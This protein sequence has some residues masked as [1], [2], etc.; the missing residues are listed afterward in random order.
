VKWLK[1]LWPVG[2]AC[3]LLGLSW[4]LSYAPTAYVNWFRLFNG[5]VILATLV[6]VVQRVLGY[7]TALSNHQKDILE[8]IS[9]GERNR[10]EAIDA[11]MQQ[12]ADIAAELAAKTVNK[13]EALMQQT[14]AQHDELSTHIAA[15]SQAFDSVANGTDGAV[16]DRNKIVKTT[17]KG[18]NDRKS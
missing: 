14:Q 17:K 18:R 13:A 6:W 10:K 11:L 9:A 4:L 1:W 8:L 7:E 3:G 15:L 16:E 12:T 5:F 2:I